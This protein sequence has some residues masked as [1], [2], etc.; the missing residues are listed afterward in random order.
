[1]SISIWVHRIV[2]FSKKQRSDE[3]ML[4]AVTGISTYSI[5]IMKSLKVRTAKTK[6]PPMGVTENGVGPNWSFLPDQVWSFLK[7][8]DSFLLQHKSSFGSETWFRQALDSWMM[9][10]NEASTVDW[11]HQ[12]RPSQFYAGWNWGRICCIHLL[13]GSWLNSAE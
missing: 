3:I 5:S 6:Q 10:H 7:V 2:P 11:A 4:S 9:R 1:M 8:L 13:L 12:V